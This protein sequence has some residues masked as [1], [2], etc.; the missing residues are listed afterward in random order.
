MG[1]TPGG[2]TNS[3]RY[4]IPNGQDNSF[5]NNFA[6]VAAL[7]LQSREQK[8]DYKNE[9]IQKAF[10]GIAPTW[11][12]HGMIQPGG[13]TKIGDTDYPFTIAPWKPNAEDQYKEAEL[14]KINIAT[15]AAPM[16]DSMLQQEAIKEQWK[17]EQTNTP[18]QTQLKRGG[19]KSVDDWRQ[20]STDSL[21]KQ[22][23][24]AQP[25][26]TTQSPEASK[27]IEDWGN[28]PSEAKKKA[29][30]DPDVQAEAKQLGIDLDQLE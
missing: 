22:L 9:A 6:Q 14:R 12:A 13:T 2:V 8:Q 26:A 24:S 1:I 18:T 5:A 20:K 16:P 10:A 21:F 3:V 11:A 25:K 29:K 30:L 17:L 28:L 7:M 23:K 27:W 19:F 4:T 15:G